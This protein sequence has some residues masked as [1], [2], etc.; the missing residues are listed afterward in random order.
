MAN[1]ED[2][3]PAGGSSG[4][5]R[6][7]NGLTAQEVAATMNEFGLPADGHA[8]GA[9]AVQAFEA[10]LRASVAGGAP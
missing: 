8:A 9:A 3:G 5:D 10:G 7:T 1:E 2:V 6:M 4:G